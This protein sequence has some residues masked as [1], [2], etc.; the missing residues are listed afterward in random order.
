MGVGKGGGEN[1]PRE[2][3]ELAVPDH[4]QEG[5]GSPLLSPHLA[6][7]SLVMA[8]PCQGRGHV[9]HEKGIQK[10]NLPAFLFPQL[11]TKLPSDR[12]K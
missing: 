3:P 8:S 11:G 1:L 5:L 9:P 7:L 6:N 4:H 12:R 10:R 2:S